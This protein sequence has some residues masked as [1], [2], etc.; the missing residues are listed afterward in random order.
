MK[1]AQFWLKRNGSPK[2]ILDDIT[3]NQISQINKLTLNTSGSVKCEIDGK[4]ARVVK[5]QSTHYTLYALA[6]DSDRVKSKKILETE[7][8]ILLS[9]ADEFEDSVKQA[10]KRAEDHT[11]RLIHN[12]KSL[13]A[14]TM[15]EIFYIARQDTMLQRGKQ[16]IAYMQDEIAKNSADAANAFMAI[17]KY[18]A[19]QNAE[20]SAFQKL[21][22]EVGQ[23]KK[24]THAIHKVL[25]N[26]FYLFFK[27]FT[28]KGV[29][30]DVQKTTATASFDYE[31][32]H[33]CIYHLVENAS[34]YV[35]NGGSFSVSTLDQG[36]NVNVVFEMESLT[37]CQHEVNKIFDE[38]Y[39]G[40]KS[41]VHNLHGSGVG[42]YVA[43]Q[44]AKINFC[45]LSAIPG[46]PNKMDPDYARNKFILSIPKV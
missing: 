29:I 24:E 3:E 14:K 42:L 30:V 17:L 2:I 36:G 20:F 43:R 23:I 32:M 39:S 15:Q 27:E 9:I 22:G 34:K 1:E 5:K 7:A 19:A 46:V 38:G 11:R 40:E 6:F 25:M 8:A 18:Q 13:T 12:L 33:V 37:I 21:T 41:R 4:A 44:L 28:D 31:S 10:T 35:R 45:T 16:A 26:V